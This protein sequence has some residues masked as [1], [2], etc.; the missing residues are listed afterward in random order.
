MDRWK[1][2]DEGNDIFFIKY[3]SSPEK[4]FR[5]DDQTPARSLLSYNVAQAIGFS[6]HTLVT[7]VVHEGRICSKEAFAGEHPN[8]SKNGVEDAVFSKGLCANGRTSMSAYRKLVRAY[9]DSL[10]RFDIYRMFALH[11]DSAYPDNMAVQNGEIVP[12]DFGLAFWASGYYDWQ[13]NNYVLDRKKIWNKRG[14]DLLKSIECLDDTTIEAIVDQSVSKC[15]E[16]TME[17]GDPEGASEFTESAA[18]YIKKSRDKLVHAVN[19]TLMSLPAIYLD[20][21][22]FMKERDAWINEKLT[23]LV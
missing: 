1:T 20:F 15:C 10:V 6:E 12:I 23:S 16:V 11:C 17:L 7:P 21:R 3:C 9:G 18:D 13:F 14:G 4:L 8:S 22:K 19:Q 2:I 5:I